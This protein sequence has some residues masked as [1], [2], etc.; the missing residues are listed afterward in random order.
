MKRQVTGVR[1][2][3]SRYSKPGCGTNLLSLECGH[4][5]R[6]KVSAPVPRFVFCKDCDSLARGGKSVWGCVLEAWDVENQ[7]PLRMT[8]PTHEAA[9]A[10]MEAST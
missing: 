2:V 5:T 1:F 3:Q 6:R 9:V 7:V 4:E 10:A 8:F